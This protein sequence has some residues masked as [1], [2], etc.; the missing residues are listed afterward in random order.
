MSPRH[1]RRALLLVAAVA[2]I[3]VIYTLSSSPPH[4][5]SNTPARAG[6]QANAA[7]EAPPASAGSITPRSAPTRGLEGASASPSVSAPATARAA[8]ATFV[9]DY[10]AWANG[11]RP[12]IR[13][14][15]ATPALLGTLHAQGRPASL[16]HTREVTLR[17][18]P[19]GPGR[20]AVS[21]AIGNFAITLERG[22]W[23]ANSDPGY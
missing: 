12:L 5:A 22:R 18:Y 10:R 13:V 9:S 1:D 7:P 21:S 2:A 23:L 20:Y 15:D 17:F 14:R 4:Q 16:R 3:A 11:Q 19:A 8:S 6:T